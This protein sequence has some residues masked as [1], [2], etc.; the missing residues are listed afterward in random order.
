MYSIGHVKDIESRSVVP[1]GELCAV[2]VCNYSWMLLAA[3]GSL[4]QPVSVSDVTADCKHV[5]S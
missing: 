1:G 2:G 5:P 3:A 4:N